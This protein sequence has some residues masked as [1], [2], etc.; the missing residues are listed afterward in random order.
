MASH[1]KAFACDDHGVGVG[2]QTIEEGRG[3]GAGM[4]E[5][6]G[7]L[8]K[9]PVG[10]DHDRALFLAQA[11]DGE[12]A[13]GP[14]LV[15]GEGA[16]CVEEAQRRL[17]VFV[18]CLCETARILG[19]GQGVDDR[20][21]PGKEHRLALEARGR[22]KGGGPRR[23]A[24][25]DAAQ[26]D[27]GGPVLEQAAATVVLPLEA[28]HLGG[29]VPATLLQS[30][31]DRQACLAQAIVGRAG[32]P[33]GRRTFEASGPVR[34]M[35]PLLARRLGGPCGIV[36]GEKGARQVPERGIDSARGHDAGRLLC[37]VLPGV[38]RLCL[39]DCGMRGSVIH[40]AI[41][42]FEPAR[43]E[44]LASGQMEGAG[45]WGQAGAWLQPIG[46]VIRGTGLVGT[47]GRHGPR[48]GLWARDVT[49][50]DD[51]APR[52]VRGEAARCELQ[53]LGF[54]PG[55][56]RQKPH[57]ALGLTGF[58]PWRPARL[59]GIGGF[60]SAR[61]VVPAAMAG[62]AGRTQGETPPVGRGVQREGVAREVGWDR[63][64]VGV[65]G[66]T[67]RPGGP[68]LRPR[69]ASA[70]RQRARGKRGVFLVPQGGGL[71]AGCA[72]Q[73]HL[74]HGCQPRP[75]GGRQG[76][77]VGEG[78]TGAA[79]LCH[80]APAVFPP[81]LCMACAHLARHETQA[82]GRGKV[83]VPRMEH[84]R[85]AHGARQHRR[86]ERVPHDG[87]GHGANGCTGVLGA[88]QDVFPGL[89]A[90]PLVL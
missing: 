32:A 5:P 79:M 14:R 61:A 15:H 59:R 26:R 65:Q 50:G 9:R 3:H 41:R 82:V 75:G 6:R 40:T 67:T 78:E 10:G 21:D 12:E 86:W 66:K 30:L 64:A 69:S 84:R 43:K 52:R 83:R 1:T 57:A 7:P 20:N 68:H 22:A 70:R 47:G 76:P 16:K 24:S 48:A 27:A 53:V 38:S 11:E 33:Q 31:D 62:E 8:L 46:A 73:P 89:G 13:S 88:R 49:Q 60:A 87:V 35:G 55:R 42:G 23:F 2:Q 54:R 80:G 29:P 77:A 17:R 85:V 63:G 74:G 45:L 90:H 72:M 28:V 58:F 36:L 71:V 18:E 39:V 51:V 44:V 25:A 56:Q 34:H 37:A 81:P 4:V 19:R